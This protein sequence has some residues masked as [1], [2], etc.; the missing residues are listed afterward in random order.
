MTA[1]DTEVI[2]GRAESV[3]A[4]PAEAVT[5]RAVAPLTK[6]LSLAEPWV[7]PGGHCYFLKGSS[8]EDELTDASRIW[9]I[10]YDLAPS[11]SDPSG[12]ILC[13]KEFSRV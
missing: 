1:A 6:L 12:A 5:V 9:D 13:V 7:Q 4:T 3:P 2:A 11:L 8:V 10:E